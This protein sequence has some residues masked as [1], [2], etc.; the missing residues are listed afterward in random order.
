MSSTLLVL[1]HDPTT[2]LGSRL[3]DA[4][5]VQ[6]EDALE[7]A[8][9]TTAGPVGIVVGATGDTAALARVALASGV[10]V[11]VEAVGRIPAD[12]LAE[13]GKAPKAYAGLRRR[14]ESDARWARGR[15]A[16]GGA[17]LTWSVHAEALAS[18]APDPL[19]EALD[20][21]DAATLLT[22]CALLGARRIDRGRGAPATW[23]LTLDHGAT[24]Q[25]VVRM[26]EGRSRRVPQPE[27]ATIRALASHGLVAA[28]LDGPLQ[29]TH[30]RGGT[31]WE[32][33]GADGAERL[34]G[35]FRDV[36]T[37]RSGPALVTLGA[38]VATRRL[39]DGS[40]RRTTTR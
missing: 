20:L 39:L 6:D 40:T 5:A 2:A 17:G 14:F 33:V 27:L 26:S 21:L 3:G 10:P 23:V 35:T 12:G 4:I 36:V 15:L 9:A 16:A 13:L 32:H 1:G 31:G 18:R 11:L 30:G 7:R 37:G 29:R 28:D 8:S 24:G 19:T 38:L 25:L 34:L 22:G